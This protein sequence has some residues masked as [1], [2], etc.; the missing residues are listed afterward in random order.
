MISKKAYIFFDELGAQRNQGLLFEWI[1]ESGL[2]PEAFKGGFDFEFARKWN[3]LATTA[4]IGIQVDYPTSD[5]FDLDTLN[6]FIHHVQTHPGW[7]YYAP[8]PNDYVGVDKHALMG[9]NPMV[10]ITLPSRTR[11][12]IRGLGSRVLSSS[13]LPPSSR[14]GLRSLALRAWNRWQTE[15]AGAHEKSLSGGHLQIMVPTSIEAWSAN[16]KAWRPGLDVLRRDLLERPEHFFPYPQ[17]MHVILLNRCNLRCTM[18]PYYSPK[19]MPHHTSDYFR[20]V[21]VMSEEIFQKVAEYAGR[22]GISLQFGQIEEPLMH[23]KVFDFLELAKR[24]GAPHVHMTTNGT[25]LDRHKA[26]R[27]ARTGIDSIMF[28][29]DALMPETYKRIRG[30]DLDELERNIEYFIHLA[31]KNGISVSVSFILQPEGRHEQEPFLEKWRRM[32]VD[33][34]TYYVLTEHDPQTGAMIRTEEMYHRGERYPCASPWI[35]S[36]IFPEGEVSLCC[37]AMTDVGWRGVVSAGDLREHSFEEIWLGERYRMVRRELMEKEF[38]EFNICINCQIW[39]ATSYIREQTALYA[40]T[41][42]ETM[43]TIHFG[44][45]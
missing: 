21:K 16:W 33:A 10:P 42:N 26:D 14:R 36:V 8:R 12:F 35:Q 39:S 28:S 18:C 31:K 15:G 24:A 43:E 41:Y 13:W 17:S 4:P 7:W 37:K 6:S 23:R 27:L 29:I 25:L 9:M 3:R 32:G 34:V 11:S 38:R 40:R 20:Q 30:R 5:P 22:N 44:G 45:N 2:S 19:Y 1:K